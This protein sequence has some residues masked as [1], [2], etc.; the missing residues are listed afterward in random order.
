M[1]VRIR[2]QRIKVYCLE[3]SY[4]VP[5]ASVKFVVMVDDRGLRVS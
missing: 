3:D 1:S 5:D 2:R 4:K